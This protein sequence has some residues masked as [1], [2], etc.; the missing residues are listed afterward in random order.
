VSISANNDAFR[1]LIEWLPTAIAVH[2]DGR[3]LY[4]NPAMVR[5]L[6]GNSSE[7]FVGRSLGEFVHPACH[8][9]LRERLRVVNVERRMSPAAEIDLVRLDGERITVESQGTPVDFDGLPAVC[10]IARDVSAERRAREASERMSNRAA[11]FA[12]LGQ[13]LASVKS[14]KEAASRILDAARELVGWDSAWLHL[15]EPE[16]ETMRNVVTFD[17]DASGVHEVPAPAARLR[18]PS[19]TTR[20]TM[21][22]G[23]QLILRSADANMNP[24]EDTTFGA[25]RISLSLMYAPIRTQDRLLGVVSLH[26][27]AADAYSHADL[28]DLHALASH[29]AGA[30]ARVL[31]ALAH[32]RAAHRLQY[33]ID[34]TE[35]GLWEWDIQK[36]LIKV[37]ARWEALLGHA[38][39]EVPVTFTSTYSREIVHPDDW[40]AV[41]KS[42]ADHMAGLTPFNFATFRMRTKSGE[43]RWFSGRSSVVEW[44]FLN[45]PTQM[46][47]TIFDIHDRKIAEAALQ[48]SEQRYRA[49]IEWSPE[50]FCVHEAGT[51]LYC[52]PA[53]VEIVAAKSPD[54]VIG[55]S[56]MDFIHPDSRQV[57]IERMQRVA[58]GEERIPLAEMRGVR[59]DGRE[60]YV[61]TQAAV[62]WFDGKRVSQV[63]ARDITA[64][65]QVEAERAALEHQLRE[66]QKLQAIGTLAG[67]IAHDFNNVLA[68][69]L[70]NTDL[71]LRDPRTSDNARESLGEVRKAALRARD[72]VQQILSF[73]RRQP[74]ERK[75]I[76]LAPLIEESVKLIR[77]TLPAH[78]ELS[79][80]ISPTQE[81]VL[82]DATQIVQI[83][84]NLCTN[85]RQAIG[86]VRGHITIRLE[87]VVA[88]PNASA[89]S[90]AAGVCI[91]V[92]DTGPGIDQATQARL[93]E[94]FFT[95]KPVN[96]GTGLGLSVVHGIVEAHEGTITV[97]SSPGAGATFRVFLPTIPETADTAQSIRQ[98][99]QPSRLITRPGGPRVIYV[100]DDEA[101]VL[102]MRVGLTMRGYDVLALT[103]PVNAL[104]RIRTAPA[105]YAALIT[106]Y[107][108][109]T[110]SGLE[111]AKQVHES[112]PDMPIFVLSGFIDERLQTLSGTA[113][114][115]GLF[116][117]GR[118]ESELME[119]LQTI[120]APREHRS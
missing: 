13:Q 21:R 99:S 87:N 7:Q 113:G 95:T 26:K 16:S 106:D 51:I 1:Q 60:L 115:R 110:L 66:S 34:A 80:E 2:R 49:L 114:I 40:A 69:I 23:P 20:R 42:A 52:N 79:V 6:G 63:V 67:G 43:Y 5:M 54:E 31:Q 88:I 85:A 117:K 107:N 82:A 68:I 72:V 10:S 53:F 4:A 111:L 97:E 3:V 77:A 108:M 96:E 118:G 12:Q 33:A 50:A 64:R 76:A 25:R 19:E 58:Q 56:L 22:E 98:D 55:R 47:G 101:M 32:E 120:I 116:Q 105:K 65:K 45:Q 39:G 91:S 17:S 93:F 46:L 30:L 78:I 61:E 75:P 104:E 119:S 84:L 70:G 36:D 102:L 71:A 57:V 8:A 11:R 59:L 37:S 92:I 14:E 86:D 48:E 112:A 24:S 83:L 94:P 103:D 100:D 9:D 44:D 73:S 109:P 28:A 27:Y 41:E 90:S 15:F 89:N 35:G 74:L 62:I 38:P 18:S 81:R 29:G